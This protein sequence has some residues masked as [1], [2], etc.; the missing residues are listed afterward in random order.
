MN[1]GSYKKLRP[2]FHDFSRTCQGLPTGKVISQIVQKCTFPVHF[3]KTLRLK[4]DPHFQHTCLKLIV[5]YCIKCSKNALQYTLNRKPKSN[6]KN[7]FHAITFQAE[8]NSRTF[9]ELAKKFKD[10][11]RISTKIQGFFKKTV[12]TL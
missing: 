8:G 6:K 9:Q 5:T 10:F 2:F 4:L 11:L 1:Q 3:N 7:T 12:Q